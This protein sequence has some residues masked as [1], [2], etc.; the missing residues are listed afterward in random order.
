[1]TPKI[2]AILKEYDVKATFF[3]VHKNSSTLENYMKQAYQEGHEIA[4]HSYTHSYKQ[5]YQSEESFLED[6]EKTR[7]W[8]QTVTGAPEPTLQYRFPGGS[9][10][11]AKFADKAVLNRILYRMGELHAIHHDWNVSSGD[12]AKIRPTKEQILH[13]IMENAVK[14]KEPVILMHDSLKNGS[15]CEALPEI[16]ESLRKEGYQFDTIS[17][18]KQPAQHKIY[19]E[20]GIPAKSERY[21]HRKKTPASFSLSSTAA[22]RESTVSKQTDTKRKGFS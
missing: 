22:A 18:I 13:N 12:A 2:L 9:S 21:L 16:I 3:V 17:R 15:T 4:V 20:S 14:Y 1:M 11:S 6:F 19:S 7:Q 10:I 8:I 5:I